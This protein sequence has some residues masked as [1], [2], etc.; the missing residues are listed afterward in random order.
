MRL[1]FENS[2]CERPLLMLR[3]VA[4]ALRARLRRL[5]GLRRLFIDA[6]ATPPH[7]EGTGPTPNS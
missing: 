7:E 4:L 5:G 3:A 1:G 6:A 2:A